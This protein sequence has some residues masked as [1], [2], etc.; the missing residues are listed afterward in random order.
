VTECE[1][2]KNVCQETRSKLS[3]PIGPPLTDCEAR[4][5]VD[6]DGALDCTQ[7][8]TFVALDSDGDGI[9]DFLDNCPDDAN[10]DQ[11]DDD[12]D[13]VGNACDDVPDSEAPCDLDC[14]LNEDDDIDQADVNAILAAVAAGGQAQGDTQSDQCG[15]RRD[16]DGDRRITFLD[17]SLCKVEFCTDCSPSAPS[18]PLG[19]PEPPPPPPPAP[20]SAPGCGIGP[21]LVLL[22]PLLRAVRRRRL[23]A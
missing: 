6:D 12:S 4:Y 7:I 23:A 1:A 21:E 3:N 18:G 2:A 14:D 16:R 17:A 13:G 19:D 8:R 9:P 15:D 10:P 5:D 11:L 20:S 22:I